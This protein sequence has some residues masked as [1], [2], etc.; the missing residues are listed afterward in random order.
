MLLYIVGLACIK[1]K[2]RAK[3]KP[4]YLLAALYDIEGANSCVGET[5]GENTSHHA[6]SVVAEVVDV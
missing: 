5:A 4:T 3:E 6:F 2:S 1:V